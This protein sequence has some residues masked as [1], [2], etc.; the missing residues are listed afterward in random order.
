M[1]TACEKD[2]FSVKKFIAIGDPGVG[3][4]DVPAKSGNWTVHIEQLKCGDWGTRISRVIVHHEKFNP[5]V[6][7]TE[8]LFWIGVDTGQ[9]GIFNSHE[10]FEL[11]FR[12]DSRIASYG[13][14]CR[15]GFG[16]GT[17]E[18]KVLNE[19]EK[20]VCVEITFIFTDKEIEDQKLIH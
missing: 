6:K 11:S 13:F 20:A 8:E 14:V 5:A 2:S 3:C 19:N 9:I 18:A 17:Y 16:D 10:R 15:S 1:T 12:G 4:I 7:L